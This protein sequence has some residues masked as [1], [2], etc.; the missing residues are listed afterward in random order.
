MPEKLRNATPDELYALFSPAIPQISSLGTV[1]HSLRAGY[2]GKRNGREGKLE[3]EGLEFNTTPYGFK[4][5]GNGEMGGFEGQAMPSGAITLA[6]RNAPGMVDD[7]VDYAARVRHVA[8][9]M[10]GPAEAARFDFSPELA[11]RLKLFLMEIGRPSKDAPN[12]LTF[13]LTSDGKGA[14]AINTKPLPE[15]LAA[16]KERVI[17]TST[18]SAS[19]QL[20]N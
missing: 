15:V 3:L 6:W 11:S 2:Q 9:V 14:L 5:S 17:G 20:G 1:T 7:A 10:V 4:F 18:P 13:D 12:T 8:E 16:Y 19:P